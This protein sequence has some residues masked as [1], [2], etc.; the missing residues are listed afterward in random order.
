M[1]LSMPSSASP[2]T[3]GSAGKEPGRPSIPSPTGGQKLQK[4][5]IQKTISRDNSEN[6][7]N[8]N[9][10][11]GVKDVNLAAARDVTLSLPASTSFNGAARVLGNWADCIEDLG[12]EADDAFTVVKGKKRRRESTN[13]PTAAAPS[14]N[15]GDARTSR[16]PQSSAGS[17]PRAQEIRTTRAHISEARARQASSS[18]EHCVYL[19]HGPELQPFHYLRALDRMLGGTAGVIQVS[20]VN[21]HQ[22]LGLANR[23]LAERLIN[24]GLEVEG[25]LLRAFPFRKRAE[26]I[27]VGNL[28]F[29]VE[30]SAIISALKPYGRV[31]SIAPKLMKAGPYTYNDGR[32]EAFIVLHDG[33]TTE[34]LPT[35]LD[36]PN[37]GEAWPA[38]LSSGIKCSRCH[39]QGHRRAN[40]PLLAGRANTTRSAPPASPAGLQP[41]TTPAPPQRP[42]PQHSAPAPPL[43]IS[44]ASPA[45]RAAIHPAGAPR[46]SPTAPSAS[47]TEETPPAP[48]PVTPDPSSQAPRDPASQEILGPANITQD[49][50]MTAVEESIPPSASSNKK[51]T[52]IDLA[53]FIKRS[54][55]V[56]FAGTDALGLGREE[57]LDLLSSRTKAHKRGRHLTPPQSNALAGLVNQILDLRP[58]GDS[59]STIYKVLR[60]VLSELRTGTAAVP[61]APTLPA[62]RPAEPA[63]PAPQKRESTPAMAT[64]PP[65]PS[66]QM[67]DTANNVNSPAGEGYAKFATSNDIATK[68]PSIGAVRAHKNWA[69]ILEYEDSENEDGYTVVQEGAVQEPEWPSLNTSTFAAKSAKVHKSEDSS[70]NNVESKYVNLPAGASNANSAAAVG[71]QTKSPSKGAEKA[72]KNWAETME[73]DNNSEEGFTV[74]KSKKR[75]HDSPVAESNSTRAN[76]PRGRPHRRGATTARIPQV[77][78]VKATHAHIADARARQASSTQDQ[79]VYIE[80]CPDFRPLH[81]LQAVDK[82]VGGAENITQLTRMNGHVLVGLA[83]KALAARLVDQGL[84][85]EGTILRTFPFRK[86]AERLLI[87]NLPFFVEDVAIIDALRPYGRVT[88]IAPIQF[89]AGEYAYT[90]GR[91]EAYILLHDGAGSPQGQL[92]HACQADHRPQASSRP[93]R[94]FFTRRASTAQSACATVPCTSTPTPPEEVPGTAPVANARAPRSVAPQPT[95]PPPPTPPGEVPSPAVAAPCTPKATLSPQASLEPIEPME[96]APTEEETTGSTPAGRG[97]IRAQLNIILEQAHNR[98]NQRAW[99]R[100]SERSLVHQV[101]IAFVQETNSFHL[102][103]GQDLCLGYS[104]VVTPPVAISGSGLACVFGPGDRLGEMDGHQGGAARRGLRSAADDDGYVTRARKYIAA[105]LEASSVKADYPS[106]SDL[107]RAIHLRRPVSVVRDDDGRVIEG[108]D[109]R[110]KALAIFWPRFARATCDPAAGAAFIEGTI[111]SIELDEEDPLHRTEITAHEVAAAIHRLPRGRAPGWDGLPCELLAVRKFLH[112]RPA[113]CVRSLSAPRC[114]ASIDAPEFNMPDP[115]GPQRSRPR[116]LWMHRVLASILLSPLEPHLPALVPECQTYAVEDATAG[117]SPLAVVCVDLQSTFDCLDRGFLLS[118]LVSLRLPAAFVGWILLLYAGA[119]ATIRDGGFQTAAISLLNGGDMCMTEVTCFAAN[120]SFKFILGAVYIHP[121]AS[122]QDIGM[123]LW[124]GLGPYIHNSQYVPPFVQVDSSIPIL[125]CGDFNKN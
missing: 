46:P 75:R 37:K 79:C 107:S 6:R 48:P 83:T 11:A 121:G 25:T 119:D 97:K 65:P 62:P 41:T 1:H 36:I 4:D 44:G 78:E 26:R 20:K 101:D 49:I 77:Q 24:E 72:L 21:G 91:R 104:A 5:E 92:P 51:C 110:R 52:R 35:R 124:Q 93:N 105:Q 58:G 42:T 113:A 39:G 10:P 80:H 94:G 9:P 22:L 16:R 76:G 120:T 89:K 18:E 102:D 122:M 90:D 34:R 55:S 30:D 60:Q 109:L 67:E 32:R 87:G 95:L 63:P 71:M 86:R 57:V 45:A 29:F 47:P 15:I 70:I 53:A 3:S 31:T 74:V 40:C 7:E 19:E 23:G 81:Y 64:P 8:A 2:G 88:S 112:G 17:V 33:V 108:P 56:S 118:L 54:P 125:L 43:E 82:V 98:H 84:E 85:I 12:P 68:K 28:P 111:T 115:Q 66:A 117:A 114:L 96:V 100:H 38:Y 73:K 27:T 14:S 50:E 123:L 116:W 13:S 103:Q 99:A 61:P 69:D 59:N 106:L